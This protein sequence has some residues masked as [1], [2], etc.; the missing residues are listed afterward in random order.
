[1][2]VV[3]LKK[4]LLTAN[5]PVSLQVDFEMEKGDW[6]TLFGKSGEGK[7]SILRMIAGLLRPDEGFI[8]VDDEVWFDNRN[9]ID[10]PVQRRK[11][12]YVFQ[13]HNLFPHMTVRENLE[14]ALSDKREGRLVEEFLN[15]VDLKELEDRMPDHLSGGQKQRV[16]LVRGLIR[17]PKIFLLDEPLS[18]LDL[19]WR[20]RLQDEILRIYKQVGA[21]TLYVTH[22]LSEVFKLSRRVFLLDGGRITAAGHPEQIFV[23]DRIS[24]EFQ[25][26]GAIL[27]MTE[28][29]GVSI[30]KILIGNHIVKTIAT[31][32]EAQH[33]RVGDKVIVSTKAFNPLIIKMR[34]SSYE[35]IR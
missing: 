17:R 5:G 26:V 30:L 35:D 22:D 21:T 29:N 28:D 14:Y 10:L 11:I 19:E 34:P 7:T 23:E 25:F 6:V 27:A 24:S 9:G 1:M 33:L 4:Q 31:G 2:I 3:H 20:L 12:G 15:L 18:S 8:Q 16:A 13:D 32:D